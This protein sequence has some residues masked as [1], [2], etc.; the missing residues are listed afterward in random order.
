MIQQL[1]VLKHE[2]DAVRMEKQNAEGEF[3]KL[4]TA[5][6]SN[7][8]LEELNRQHSLNVEKQTKLD[9]QIQNYLDK[10]GKG[11]S[12]K[13]EW[14]E[15]LQPR[16]LANMRNKDDDSQNLISAIGNGALMTSQ[17]NR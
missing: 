11:K 6:Q 15:V 1:T 5:I 4:R 7:K 14:A 12:L 8:G 9:N 13:K 3:M 17:F 2:A 10:I 16:S